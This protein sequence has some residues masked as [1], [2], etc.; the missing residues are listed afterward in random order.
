M[1]SSFETQTGTLAGS[2]SQIAW[3]MRGNT[4]P[5]CTNSR[6]IYLL[7]VPL[8]LGV[9]LSGCAGRFRIKRGWQYNWGTSV[10]REIL[11]LSPNSSTAS[12]AGRRIL[13]SSCDLRCIYPQMNPTISGVHVDAWVPLVIAFFKSSLDQAVPMLTGITSSR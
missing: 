5:N 11:S 13:K 7:V 9:P 4:C 3:R 12:S 2:A 8:T 1:T 10:M 6:T